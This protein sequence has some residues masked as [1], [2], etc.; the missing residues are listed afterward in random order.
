V[1]VTSPKGT[2]TTDVV[3]YFG[4]RVAFLFPKEMQ[5][6]MQKNMQVASDRVVDAIVASEGSVSTVIDVPEENTTA[7][8]AG[9]PTPSSVDMM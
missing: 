3:L 9:A 2:K 6:L 7:A 4:G 8:P 5:G 1:E